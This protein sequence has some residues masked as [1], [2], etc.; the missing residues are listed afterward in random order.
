MWLWCLRLLNPNNAIARCMIFELERLYCKTAAGL[1]CILLS[2]QVMAAE[3]SF[4]PSVSLHEEYNDNIRFTANPHP[5]VWQ[6][7]I[8][9]SLKFNNKTE[10]S[11]VSGQMQLG[12]NRYSGD[13]S[14]NRNDQ[15]L[16]LFASR[17]AERNTWSLNTSYRRDTTSELA[18]TGLVRPRVQRTALIINPSWA[19]AL[20][21]RLSLRLDYTYQDVKY[22]S[23]TSTDYKYKHAGAA[24]QYVLSERDQISLGTFYSKIDYAP[25]SLTTPICLLGFAGFCFVP[26][27]LTSETT[28]QSAT[29]GMQLDVTH[30]F[31]ETTTGSFSLGRRYI[32]STSTLKQTTFPPPTTLVDN[33]IEVRT[34]TT[35]LGVSLEKQFDTGA[36]N[37]F[38]RREVNPSGNGLVTTDRYTFSVRKSLTENCTAYLDTSVYRTTYVNAG[39]A[40]SRYYTFEPRLSWQ[41]SEWWTLS[42][43]YRYAKVKYD[44]ATRPVTANAV[45][46]NLN[47]S[48]PKVSISR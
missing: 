20:S 27:S 4:E 36:V 3:W 12:I 6:T 9:P 35:S 37:G 44:D 22:D 39:S 31:S 19:Y 38:I 2:V 28:S 47:Y 30:L 33:T 23:A 11:E 34:N 1:C 13:A 18:T 21:S 48:W 40:G 29:R 15:L 24:L 14:L 26:G 46:V 8:R 32:D 10:I 5:R 16:L 25:T 43:G 45:Y 42:S 17:M 41:L 7:S